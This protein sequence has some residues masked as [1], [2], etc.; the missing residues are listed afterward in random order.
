MVLNKVNRSDIYTRDYFRL[1]CFHSALESF[2]SKYKCN[3]AKEENIND[4]ISFF[5]S[6]RTVNSIYLYVQ[7]ASKSNLFNPYLVGT[8]CD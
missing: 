6:F 1:K 3:I 7:L 2:K 8:E 4:R 5:Y